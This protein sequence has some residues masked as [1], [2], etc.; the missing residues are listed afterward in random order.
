MLPGDVFGK[1]VKV[2]VELADGKLFVFDGEV[3]FVSPLIEAG[4]QYR[5]WA[6]V[7]NRQEHGQWLLRPGMQAEMTIAR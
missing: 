2:V 3:T 4:S 5:I 7:E 1:P 6:E